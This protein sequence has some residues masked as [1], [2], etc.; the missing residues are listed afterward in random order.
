MM[1]LVDSF[2]DTDMKGRLLPADGELMTSNLW[3]V[4]VLYSDTFVP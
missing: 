3:N 2:E 4:F 1:I